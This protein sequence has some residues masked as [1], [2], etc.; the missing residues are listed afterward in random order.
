MRYPHGRYAIYTTQ[1]PGSLPEWVSGYAGKVDA[2]DRF[3]YFT[4][5]ARNEG[6]PTS[7]WLVD[8]KTGRVI[9]GNTIHSPDLS[10]PVT[11]TVPQPCAPGV[12]KLRLNG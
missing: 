5:K 10:Q 6:S 11:Q 2:L 4:L 7:V 1:G 12:R 3:G 8:E 9:V